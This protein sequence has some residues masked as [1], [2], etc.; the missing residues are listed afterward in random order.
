MVRIYLTGLDRKHTI[1]GVT[2]ENVYIGD[3]KITARSSLLD[4]NS[5]VSKVTFK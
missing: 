1:N 4:K 2:F 3:E 5:Y